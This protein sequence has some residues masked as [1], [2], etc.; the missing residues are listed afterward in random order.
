MINYYVDSVFINTTVIGK[1]SVFKIGAKPFGVKIKN[2]FNTQYMV[3]SLLKNYRYCIIHWFKD[4]AKH[5]GNQVL[6]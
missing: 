1:Y 5:S 6:N 2:E 4:I 3:C